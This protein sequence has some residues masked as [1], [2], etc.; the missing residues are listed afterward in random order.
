MKN[1]NL[2]IIALLLILPVVIMLIPPPEGLTPVAWKIFAIYVSAI[3]GLML[4]PCP[5]PVVLLIAIAASSLIVGNLADIL[6]AGYANTI[7]WLIFAAFSLGTALKTTNLGKRIAYLLMYRLGHSTLGMSYVIAFLDLIL[8]P[9]TPS[10]TARGGGIVCPIV[11]NIS[12]TL[13]SEPGPTG[14]KCGSYLMTSLYMINQTTSSIFMTGMTANVMALPMYASILNVHITWGTWLMASVVPGMLMLMLIPSVTYVLYTPELKKIDGRSIAVKGLEELGPMKTSEK[15]LCA[16]FSM[17]LMGWIFGHHYRIDAG[18]VAIVAMALCLLT[19]IINWEDV[20]STKGGFCTLIWFGGI[21]GLSG[22]LAGSGFFSWLANWMTGFIPSGIDGF[23]TLL[24]IVFLSVAIRYVFAS[25][26]A[27]AASMIP[28][29]LTVGL[30]AGTPPTALALAIAFSSGYAGKITH[31]GGAPAPI[32][33]GTGYPEIKPWWIVGGV[34]AM[35]SY[36]VH[37]TVGVAWWRL[38]GLYY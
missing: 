17:A 20:L 16:I 25:A 31:Y 3:L 15:I 32:I 21:L 8:A 22:V 33:Y 37:M 5:E 34:L 18:T 27:Y 12:S 2:Y 38:L 4:K 19:G 13:G 23:T 36:V 11:G 9:V 14:R 26:T 10:N 24:V 6:R 29:F 7:T 30:A 1:N 28:V 35:L